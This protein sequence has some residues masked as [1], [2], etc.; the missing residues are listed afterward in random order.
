M[1][2]LVVLCYHSISE[3][4]PA[5]TSV[6]PDDFE[7]QLSEFLRR[8]YRGATFADAL[9]ASPY[10]RTL[11]VTFDDAHRSV[12][13]L[14]APVMQRLGVPGTIYVP[15]DYAGTERL[16]GWDGYDEWMGTEHESEL[17]CMG[18]DELIELRDRGWEIAS[19]TCSHPRLSRLGEAEILAELTESRRV[20]EERMGEPC[21]SLAYPYSDYDDRVVR[22]AGEAGY[23]FASTVPRGPAP[24]LPLAW[25]RVG[26]YFG[27]D[28]RRITLRSRV[29]RLDAPAWAR[30]AMA[31]KR[32]R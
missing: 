8:G 18:W 7:R 13:Q 20:C 1:N 32:I 29:R 25:P 19:H 12:V 24:P 31:L 15:T 22:A 17:A 5:S 16:M 23:R 27:E 9:T 3:T 11:V 2:D 26:V 14:A 28:A 6:K 30:A 10:E 4:W 21:R